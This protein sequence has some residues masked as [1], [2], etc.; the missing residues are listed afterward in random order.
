MAKYG[1]EKPKATILPAYFTYTKK[2]GKIS[3]KARSIFYLFGQTV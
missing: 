1:D 3:Q 2:R